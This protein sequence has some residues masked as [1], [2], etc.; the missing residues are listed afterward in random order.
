[1]SSVLPFEIIELI[2]EAVGENKETNLLNKLALVSLFFHQIC[3]KRLFATIELHDVEP[4]YQDQ[5][6]S[7]KKRFV[8]LLN[9]SPDVV[10]YI[11]ELTYTISDRNYRRSSFDEDDLPFQI[12]SEQFLVSNVSKSMV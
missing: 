10:K 4:W 3:S 7:P 8:N 2:I 1:M 12:S 6:A 9:S 5:V 11:R